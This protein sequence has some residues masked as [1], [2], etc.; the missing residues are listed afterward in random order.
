MD[1]RNQGEQ[2]MKSW[3]DTQQTLLTN[4]LGTVQGSGTNPGAAVWGQLVSAWQTSVQQTLDTQ[5]KWIRT[6]TESVEGMAGKTGSAGE[7]NEQVRMGQDLLLRWTEAQQQF[8]QLWFDAAKNLTSAQQS[9]ETGMQTVQSLM[10]TWQD[11]VRKL[12]EMQ[13]AWYS[14]WTLPR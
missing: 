10:Q 3:A 14:R 5:R 1:A 13:S 6:W 2:L 9:S 8:W 11:S 4:W 12:M 7:L